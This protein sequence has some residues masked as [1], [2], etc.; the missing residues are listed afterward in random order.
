MTMRAAQRMPEAQSTYRDMDEGTYTEFRRLLDSEDKEGCVRYAL[1]LLDSGGA[2]IPSLYEDVLTPAAREQHCLGR[3]RLLCIWE[4]HI[5]T[6]IIRT[7]LECC[8][9]HLMEERRSRVGDGSRGRTIIVCP[10]E[11]YHELGARMTADFFTLCGFDVTFVGANTPQD[12]IVEAAGALQ[13]EY[14]GVSVTSPYNLVAA[15][16]TLGHLREVRERSGGT[17]AIVVG[18]QAFDA[19]DQRARNMGADALAQTFDDICELT[20]SRR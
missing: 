7:V 5:R 18:G 10:A 2:D 16:R 12:E 3:E 1:S 15:R 6:S 20:G 4:E 8:Y 13:P 11:E 9:P 17:F 14:I 19:D